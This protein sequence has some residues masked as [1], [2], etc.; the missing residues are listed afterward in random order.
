MVRG[1]EGTAESG[2]CLAIGHK[3]IG[4]EDAGLCR[5]PIGNLAGLADEAVLHLYGVG[6]RTAIRDDRIL[7]DDTRSDVYGI[8]L[9]TQDGT[10]AQAGCSVNL[11]LVLD[12]GIGDLLGVDNLDA[13]T[14]RAALGLREANLLVHQSGEFVLQLL[15]AEML[16]HQGSQL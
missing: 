4:K 10:V 15:V 8:I 14:Y 11:A 13:I 7:A 5:E 6:N 16:H 9:G 2:T 1:R 3:R 12:N